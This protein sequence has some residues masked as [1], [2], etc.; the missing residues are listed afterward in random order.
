MK[1]QNTSVL[2]DF[3]IKTHSEERAS[4][5]PCLP[6]LLSDKE[7]KRATCWTC[8]DSNEREKYYRTVYFSMKHEF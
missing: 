8:D 2:E 4:V 6:L 5:R 7:R 1:K 3:F